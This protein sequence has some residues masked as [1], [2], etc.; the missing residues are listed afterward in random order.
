MNIFF[1]FQILY[2][3]NSIEVF[4]LRFLL[5]YEMV[6]CYKLIRY[7]LI[8]CT[9]G[10]CIWGLTTGLGITADDILDSKRANFLRQREFMMNQ[11]DH[12]DQE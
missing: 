11:S 3:Y 4:E 6:F 10:V 1:L 9:T 7:M 2:K 12:P 5:S 8:I